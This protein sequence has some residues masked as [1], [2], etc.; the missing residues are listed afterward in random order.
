MVS[1]RTL[2]HKLN[3]PLLITILLGQ[4]IFLVILGLK[5]VGTLESLDLMVY[6]WTLRSRTILSADSRIIL[7][8]QTEDDLRRWGFPVPDGTLSTIL[9]RLEDGGAQ[10]IGVDKYR[11]I[12]VAPGQEQLSEVLRKHRNIIW[13][14]KFGKSSSLRVPPPPE[15]K[16]TDQVGFNDLT[17][18]AGGV[19]RRGALFMDDGKETSYAFALVIA[20]RYLE[21]YGINLQG[22]DK[23][24]DFV[25]IG[26]TTLPPFESNE[27]GYVDEDAAGYQFLI[28]Y[29]TMPSR[30]PIYTFSDVLDGKV[31]ADAIKGKIVIIGTTA[32]SLN[33]HFYTPYSGGTG[34]HQ[35]IAGFELH[36][37]IV[38]Q[39][40]EMA[41]KGERHIHSLSERDEGLLLWLAC[42]LSAL[43]GFRMRSL[44]L[45]GATVVLG[46]VGLGTLAF[47]SIGYNWW[48]P[49]LPALFGW[50]IS[51]ST[52][53]AYLSGQ[54]RNQRKQL[55]QIF[56]SHVSNDVAEAMWRERDQFLDGHRPRP[57]QITATVMFTDIRGFTTI[58]EKLDP[59]A[60]FD[61]LNSYMEVMSQIV[62]VHHGMIN[63]YIGDAVMAL[64]GVPIP[65]TTEAEIARDATSAV[66]C[67]LAMRAA[68]EK[69]N[70]EH[71]DAPPLGMRIGIFTGQLAAGTLGSAQRV[72]YTVIGDTVNV[73][74]RL[75]SYKG[76]EDHEACRI[77]IG[78]R[79]LHCLNNRYRTHLVGSIQLKGKEQPITVFQ[80][81][82]Y[83]DNPTL[84]L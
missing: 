12:S 40:I 15:L 37:Q 73:A 47:V 48:I 9:Q 32:K 36:A 79:T 23:N 17:D 1:L 45:F 21:Q 41:L 7:V 80:V 3:Q 66:D 13:I 72:E 34:I 2:L 59:P 5:Q 60:L 75:E 26:N 19:I 56:S 71:P 84:A 18:D 42:T 8:D 29:R 30:L 50:V 10:V 27:G 62:L 81:D 28:D 16:G 35:R 68:I 43:I 51:A 39:L 57:Q 65:R 6:D 61:W 52:T 69:M 31:P 46:I 33:D 78:E 38:N 11:D 44:W 77:L 58:S 64:F 63:K 83:D 74:S 49:I 20:L 55:M 25:K 82:D 67:A 24:P 4:I 54:E 76:V 70:A 22:D 53:V 14:S